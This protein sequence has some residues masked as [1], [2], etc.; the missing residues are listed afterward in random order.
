MRDVRAAGVACFVVWAAVGLLAGPTVFPTGV[1]LYKPDRA[2]NSYVLFDGRDGKSHLIDMNGNEVKV[3][4]YAGF[5]S[6][7][8][9]PT[10]NG[11]KRG[12]I[13]AQT[14][15]T[16]GHGPAMF[17][18][19]TLA[20][21]D[22]EGRIVWEWGAKAPGGVANQNH[23]QHRLANGNT[24][25]ISKIVHPVA[26]FASKEVNDQV[27]Y[28][29]NPAGDIVWRW[30]S[31]E[32]LHEMG[33]SEEALKMTR[34]G[35]SVSGAR[36]GFLVLNDMEP[37]GPNKWHRAGDLRFHPDNIMTDS[38]EGNFV[39]I[40]EK[41][42]GR[43]VW[44]L[45]PDYPGMHES[46]SRRVFNH[47]VPRPVDQMIGIHDSHLIKE[48]L[49]GAGHV[50][51]FDNQGSAGFPPAYLSSFA[52]SRVLEIDPIKK[53]IVWQYTGENSGLPV[54]TFYSSF[55]SGAQRLPNGNTLICEGVSGR[56][57]QVTPQGEIIW[58]YVSPHFGKMTLGQK[59]ILTNFVFRAQPVPYDWV[60][61]G[62]PRSEKAVTPP[63]LA[64]FRVPAGS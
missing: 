9:D 58:E 20:E 56:I 55:I 53:E 10:I 40:I 33:F 51:V 41:K 59:E 60:P 24:L 44:R 12:H 17:N 1:T 23:D 6:E 64:T 52:G 62:T 3:W 61:A 5:P 2:H 4:N 38:R 35:F 8:I 18:N 49:P 54:W 25:L 50:L 28:E 32:H 36:S 45:G 57:F 22:W 13:F 21:L 39:A 19:K 16:G 48:G 14:E 43:I 30:V 29:V 15:G 7:M 63:P 37:L 27:I 31:S 11:G 26:G 47:T 42:T 46:P 34:S